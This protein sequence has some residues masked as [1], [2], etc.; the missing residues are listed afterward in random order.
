MHILVVIICL[1]GFCNGHDVQAQ[2]TS[3]V[4]DLPVRYG[5]SDSLVLDLLRS[6]AYLY[7][8]AHMEYGSIQL[9]AHQ[10][11]QDWQ[12]RE[13]SA[14]AGSDSSGALVGKPSFQDGDQT[15]DSERIR[16]NFKTRRASVSKLV[17]Q[18]GELYMV[19]RSVRLNN[20]QSIYMK[21]TQMTTCSN[22]DA[23]HFFLNLSKAHIVPNKRVVSGPAYLVMAG[24]PLPVGLPFAIIPSLKGQRSG[25]LPP[26]YGRSPELG[27]FLRNLGYYFALSD[28]LDLTQTVTTQRV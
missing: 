22:T 14:T 28:Y 3:S 9:K 1:M 10:I 15:F 27:F 26:E 5:S 8:E 16:Y 12:G 17:T 23:P 4:L 11:E 2:D 19:G 25:L 21:N 18:D 13:V 7:K 20:D 6:R 24:V